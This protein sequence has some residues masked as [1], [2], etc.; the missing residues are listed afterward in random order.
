MNEH[1]LTA[2]GLI[3]PGKLDRDNYAQSLAEEA[4]RTGIMTEADVERIRGDLLTVL[5][6]VIGY[7][8][9]GESTN[10]STEEARILSESLLYNIGT[11][12]RAEGDPDTAARIMKERP[13]EEL[14]ARGY[15]I[16]KK[17]FEE[18]RTLW[19]R[20][21]YTRLR[22]GGEEY[23]RAIDKRIRIYLEK[24]D[25]RTSAHDKLYLSLPK[26]RIRGAFHIR[27]AVAV[28]RRLLE[29]NGGN[30]GGTDAAFRVKEE[31]PNS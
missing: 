26:Y 29:V 18:A 13:M 20:V 12:L 8:T 5:A 14:Y 23:D 9:G 11:A 24:Y 27:G 15:Q 28:L 25:P 4:L 21:R 10:V 17:L 19:N 6:Q 7:K 22:D 2:R 16:N 1:G 30:G 3:D 31:A